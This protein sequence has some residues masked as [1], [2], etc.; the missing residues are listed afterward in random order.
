MNSKYLR[1]GLVLSL[2]L[3]VGLLPG[4]SPL[5][6]QGKGTI[7]IATQSPLS[8]GQSALGEGIKLGTQL[9]EE[10]FKGSLEK[11]GFK[12]EVVPY[13]DQAKPDVGVSNA[14]NMIADKDIM[15]VIGHLNSGVAI[16][17]SEV[18]KEVNLAMISPANTNEKVT[19]RGYPNV[20]RVCGRDDVQGPVGAEFA[21]GALKVKTVYIV[22][23][24]TTYGQGVAEAF[25]ADLEKKGVK[26][27][28]F[29]GTEEKSNFDPIITPIKAK[30]PDLIYFGGIY[31]QGAPF[32]KQAREKGV[33]SKFLGPD[34]MDSS[35]LVKIAGKAVVGMYY[36]TA[37]APASSPQA[38]QFGEEYKKKFSK[39][40]EPYAAESYVSAAIAIKALEMATAGGKAPTRDAVTAAI[41]K[42]KYSGMTGTIEFDDKGDPKRASYYV[43]QVASDN[44]EKWAENKEAKRLAIAAPAAKK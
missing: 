44:P 27:V 42:V 11:A 43:M 37:A 12:V 31:D 34:G 26:V 14:K 1:G 6:A 38:K 30:N 36:T 7:K 10:K 9:G 15:V 28:G 24:K 16:P 21:G 32:F 23:D 18:Y 29:E 22:H 35:D 4:A 19:D 25:K 17:S 20:N 41:R 33:K 40:P 3:A 2:A 13:D 8:G 5:Q 39:N